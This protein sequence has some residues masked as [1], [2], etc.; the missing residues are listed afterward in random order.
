MVQEDVSSLTVYV[1]DLQRISKLR[2]PRN[3]RLQYQH[4]LERNADVIRRALDALEEKERE[5]LSQ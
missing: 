2:K 3:S 4:R 5:A 1:K